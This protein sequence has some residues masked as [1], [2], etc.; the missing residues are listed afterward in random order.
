MLQGCGQDVGDV[1][2]WGMRGMRGMKQGLS[3]DV[4]MYGCG[5]P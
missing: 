2:M 3:R 4:R 5:S 1:G